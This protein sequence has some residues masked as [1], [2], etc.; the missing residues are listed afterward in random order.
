MI[1]IISILTEVYILNICIDFF[2]I[3]NGLSLI[4]S[5]LIHKRIRIHTNLDRKIIRQ[6]FLLMIIEV[7]EL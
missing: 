3:K 4:E 6:E 1:I 2:L 5:N 7:L